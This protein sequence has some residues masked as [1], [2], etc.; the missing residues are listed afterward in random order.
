[1]NKK[2]LT[3]TTLNGFIGEL[4][5]SGELLPL[6]LKKQ[7]NEVIIKKVNFDRTSELKEISKIKFLLHLRTGNP[8]ALASARGAQFFQ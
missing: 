6:S 3:F 1:M 8:V 7:T 2:G 5:E 4:I